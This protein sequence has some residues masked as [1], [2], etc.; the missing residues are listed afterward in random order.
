M[1]TAEVTPVGATARGRGRRMHREVAAGAMAGVARGVAALLL[2]DRPI[3]DVIVLGLF[4]AAMAYV[5]LV[6]HRTRRIPNRVTVPGTALALI[7]AGLAGPSVLGASAG[8][9]ALAFV[10]TILV[11]AIARGGFGMGDVKLAALCGAV[12]GPVAVPGFLAVGAVLGMGGAL[13]ALAR[14]VGRRGTIAL[15]PYLAASGVLYAWIAGPV[16]G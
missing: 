6:D 9:A 16:I 4:S 15:G 12:L 2:R 10:V 5:A 7:A 13:V 8:G 14:G 1:V 3:L 11:Y